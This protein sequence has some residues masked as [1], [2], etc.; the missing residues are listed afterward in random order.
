MI[1]VYNEFRGSILGNIICKLSF[2]RVCQNDNIITEEDIV[3]PND[4]NITW[5]GGVSRDPQK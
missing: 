3:C 2:W 1:A 5:G 4:Y